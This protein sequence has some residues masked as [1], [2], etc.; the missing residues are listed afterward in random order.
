M[1]KIATKTNAV[2]ALAFASL[3]FNGSTFADKPAWAG[4]DK[5]EEQ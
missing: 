1:K 4:G 3:L 2:L 5:A